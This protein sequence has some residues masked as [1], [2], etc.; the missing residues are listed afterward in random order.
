ML[1]LLDGAPEVPLR[2]DT[3]GRLA[4]GTLQHDQTQMHKRMAPDA[5]EPVLELKAATT[6]VPNSTSFSCKAKN[7]PGILWEL[8]AGR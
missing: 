3:Q 1:A 5:F 6:F 2:Q 7:G 4:W 8:H